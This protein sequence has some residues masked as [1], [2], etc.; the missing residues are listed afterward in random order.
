MIIS[1]GYIICQFNGVL[2]STSP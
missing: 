1:A 2:V